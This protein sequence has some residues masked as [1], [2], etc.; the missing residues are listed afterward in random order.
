MTDPNRL[1]VELEQDASPAHW[2]VQA[3][4]LEERLGSPYRM[5]VS[6]AT[7]DLEA[8]PVSFLGQSVLLT[9]TRDVVQRRV[10]G[11]VEAVEEGTPH[12]ERILAHI[13]VVPALEAL[14]HRVD[15][16]VF[17]EQTVPEILTAVLG[18]ALGAYGRG[19]EDRTVRTYP[20]CDYRVQYDE[21]DFDFCHRLMEEEGIAYWFDQEGDEERLVL[22]DS[23]SSYGEITS[24]HGRSCLVSSF[25]V[26]VD[27]Q[28]TVRTFE[29]TSRLAPTKVATRHFAWGAPSAP[30]EAESTE[31]MGAGDWPSGAAVG[32][33][34]EVY[35]HEDQPL[36]TDP[37]GTS[38]GADRTDRAQMARQRQ[39]ADARTARGTTT[40]VGMTAGG[41]FELS[42]HA[43]ADLDGRYLVT[44]TR[45]RY[46][47]GG[48]TYE[49]SIS[50]M[51]ADVPFRPARRT[52][53]PRVASFQTATVVGP[54]GE[55][56]HTDEHGR[57]KVQFHWDRLGSGDER[58]SAWVRVMQPW[59]G[60]GWGF[61]FLP[62][63]G[64][65]VV[66]RFVDGDPD[67][68]VVIGSV[69]N[70]AHP[71]PYALPGDK[72]KSTIRTASSLGGAGFNE[73]R[74]EDAAGSEEIFT[75]AQKDQNEVVE[76][77]HTTTVHH[78]QRIRVDHDQVQEVGNDQVEHVF[79]NQDLEVDADRTVRV[80]GNFDETVDGT[81]TRRV[82]GDVSETFSAN[83]T[84][85]VAASVS[86]TIGGARTQAI[87]GSSTETIAG[88]LTQ[89]I[90]GG[91][92][93]TTPATYTMSADGGFTIN[94][95]AGSK[96]VSLGRHTLLA[97]GGQRIVDGAQEQSGFNWRSLFLTYDAKF[98][99]K[100][101]VVLAMKLTY[102]SFKR[103]LALLKLTKPGV[104]VKGTVKKSERGV[105]T[106]IKEGSKVGFKVAPKNI[107]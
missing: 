97:P 98:N 24:L 60:S 5:R 8:A 18:E 34:R 26:D 101:S 2:V 12:A 84:R 56:I 53:R 6:L 96:I 44:S 81:E 39:V 20:T 79:A 23:H 91:A 104:A 54:S 40:I 47:S 88:S 45:H 55:E 92:S 62:R 15:T 67:R 63:M 107:L 21:S 83:E 10:H 42:G 31:T 14:R 52:G 48:D 36:T 72:T 30:L 75:H 1:Q 94:S 80:H 87:G 89:T 59:A 27:D 85:S 71:P 70:G 106:I 64:M 86:E 95:P 77:D 28:E 4:E 74:F 102:A 61:V 41:V 105:V 82:T 32:P 25:A 17:Q 76:N 51:P 69:Y 58:S 73:W 43:R 9:M 38:Y 78:D 100:L 29:V 3:F 68:P 33:E 93:I 99:T 7:E 49:N 22:T 46:Q 37:G 11:I 66:V 50:C 13:R 65:E 103:N 19:V 90:A 35:V 57:V 16:R